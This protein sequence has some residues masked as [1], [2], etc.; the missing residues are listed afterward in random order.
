MFVKYLGCYTVPTFVMVNRASRDPCYD[1]HCVV[2][3][4]GDNNNDVVNVS[5]MYK[6]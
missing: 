6:W 1:K 2:I 4:S 5:Y 3:S